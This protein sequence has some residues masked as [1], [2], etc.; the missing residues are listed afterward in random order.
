MSDYAAAA[1]WL[2]EFANVEQRLDPR[3]WA[4]VKLE[5]VVA[6][7]DRLDHPE[8]AAAVVHIAG[9]KGKG[10][11]AALVEA[12]LRQAGYRTG[13]YTSPHLVSPRE[14]IRLSGQPITEELAADLVVGRLQPAVAAYQTDPVHGTL[15]WFDLHTALAWLAFQATAVDWAVVEVGLG[16]RLDATNVVQPAVC[17]ITTLCLEHTA[18]LGDRLEQIA[19]EKA[20]IIKPG[21]PL[22][23][24]PQEPAAA[25]VLAARAAELAAPL[26]PATGVT[27]LD[28]LCDHG[29]RLTQRLELHWP[30][31]GGAVDCALLG[32]HQA[33]NAAVARTVLERLPVDGGR[34]PWAAVRDGFAQARWPGRVEV[35]QRR[36]WLILDGAH[37]PTAAAQLRRTL[38]LLPHHRRLLVLA[39]AADK[40]LPALVA[41]LAADCALVL[42][43]SV[44]GN[45]R[46]LP[47]S[48][49]A[50]AVRAAGWPVE[51][52]PDPAAAV[53]A[54]LQQATPADAVVVS[55]SLYLVGAVLAARGAELRW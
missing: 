36:P 49:V 15:T 51:Q 1:A 54:A 50:A 24:A 20:G 43:T 31:A 12:V 34:L 8:R 35:L 45:P 16:G 13:L 42:A 55:G 52:H 48:T 18:L 2:A 17:A 33:V 47:A 53:A 26:H 23:S 6:L 40:D 32:P 39:C 7:L 27:V 46:A 14:R 5:R 41:E 3:A 4:G 21:V 11:V 25:A 38:D 10:S 30:G 28:A 44:P 29:D 19:A 22:V 37:T 9:S